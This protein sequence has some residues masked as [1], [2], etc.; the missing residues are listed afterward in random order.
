MKKLIGL[1]IVAFTTLVANAGIGVDPWA[2]T[3]S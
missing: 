3:I 2:E 1:A